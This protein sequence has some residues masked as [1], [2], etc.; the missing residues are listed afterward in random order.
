[1]NSMKLQKF[2]NRDPHRL[3]SN[4][5]SI[6]LPIPFLIFDCLITYYIIINTLLMAISQL[7]N[8]NLNIWM[9]LFNFDLNLLN[10]VVGG[11]WG[12]ASE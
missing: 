8:T 4:I 3:N 5:S 1:M 10:W 6:I 12:E 2:L 11:W 9:G 7:F